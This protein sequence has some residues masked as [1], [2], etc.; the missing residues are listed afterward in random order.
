MY[1]IIGHKQDRKATANEE[2]WKNLNGGPQE[3]HLKI[4]ITSH[5]LSL[6]F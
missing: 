4:I 2:F 3:G 1:I 6:Y 5:P